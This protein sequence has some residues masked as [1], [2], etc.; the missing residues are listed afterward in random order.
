MRA[1]TYIQTVE[2]G[3]M[4]ASVHSELVH[5]THFVLPNLPGVLTPDIERK[6]FE[7]TTPPTRIVTIVAAQYTPSTLERWVQDNMDESDAFL[8]VGGNDKNATCMTS[9]QAIKTLKES[10]TPFHQVFAVANPN[11]EK[12]ID[13]AYEKIDA[14]ATGIITQPLLCGR[15]LE[16][17]SEYPRNDVLYIAGMALPKTIQN[18]YFWLKLLEQPELV[19]DALFQDHVKYFSSDKHVDSLAWIRN[20]QSSLLD[21]DID[22]IHYMPVNNT[23]DLLSI[24]GDYDE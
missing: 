2:W 7:S 17:L 10:I 6:F 11:D 24:L 14:G 21:V 12:S 20:Q 18:L 15:A 4:V 22:G 16:I 19:E 3:R 9:V 5:A 13:N 8:V 23:R 1:G